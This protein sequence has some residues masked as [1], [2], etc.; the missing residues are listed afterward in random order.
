MFCQKCGRQIG[1]ANIFC[2]N[3]GAPVYSRPTPVNAGFPTQSAVSVNHSTFYV[4]I[5]LIAA[6]A[7]TIFSVF[8][9]LF[10]MPFSMDRFVDKREIST[11]YSFYDFTKDIFSK[12]IFKYYSQ[13]GYNA[14]DT[15]WDPVILAIIVYIAAIIGALFLVLAIKEIIA[16]TVPQPQRNIKIAKRLLITSV[17]ALGQLVFIMF[18]RFSIDE[19][20]TLSISAWYYILL[21]TAVVAMCAELYI[22]KQKQ[23]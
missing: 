19:E 9:K 22:I 3:C 5:V 7:A 15:D 16:S 12:D 4:V 23:Y 21:V 11:S 2:P 1:E 17:A 18:F 6:N 20:S 14:S 10:S 13:N 8:F